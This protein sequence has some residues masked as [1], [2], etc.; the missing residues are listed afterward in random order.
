M[1]MYEIYHLQVIA[2]PCMHDSLSLQL[3]TS[4]TIVKCNCHFIPYMCDI[5]GIS[6]L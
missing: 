1:Y 6:L 2:N 5:V 3:E 4:F